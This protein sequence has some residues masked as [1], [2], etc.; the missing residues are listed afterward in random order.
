MRRRSTAAGI[1]SSLSRRTKY[2]A[3][4]KHNSDMAYPVPYRDVHGYGKMTR[5]K[6][7]MILGASTDADIRELKRR[8]RNL[9]RMTHPDSVSE[10]DYP[11]EVH[12]INEAYNYLLSHLFDEEHEDGANGAQKI[13]WDAPVNENAY[14]DRAIYQYVE[15]ANGNIIGTITVDAGK[16]MWIEDEDFPLFLKSLYDTAKSVIAEDDSK[17]HISRSDDEDLLKDIAYLIAGQFFGSDAS[18]SLMKQETDGSYHTKA[19]IEIG[20]GIAINDGEALYPLQV[21][22]HRLYVKNEA[23]K[24]V[25]YLTFRDD[26]MLF[27]IVPLFERSAVKVKMKAGATRGMSVDADLWIMPIPEDNVTIIESINE[28]IRRLLDA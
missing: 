11:Y 28:K 2:A 17:K 10:H 23:G 5:K 14:T 18:L 9:M 27:G 19:M 25:G 4:D 3:F 16:F 15:D 6:A 12:E 13:R 22:D 7:L 8:Y 26:R 24:E 21:R 1:C 20:G